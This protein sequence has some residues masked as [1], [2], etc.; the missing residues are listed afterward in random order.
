MLVKRVVPDPTWKVEPAP[1]CITFSLINAIF[2][3]AVS[4]STVTDTPV[5]TVNVLG[6]LNILFKILVV[7]AAVSYTHL[8]LPTKRIV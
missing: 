5:P 6:V 2:P 8:T 3:D 4:D 1:T 7:S